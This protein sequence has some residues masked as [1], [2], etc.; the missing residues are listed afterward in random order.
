MPTVGEQLCAARE[1]RKLD[2]SQ[3]ADITKIKSDHIRAL[4]KGDFSCFIAT[5]YIRGFVRTYSRLLKLDEP[6]LLSQLDLELGQ[7]EKFRNQASGN[8][9]S[10]SFLDIVTYRLSR[11]NLKVAGIV[12]GLVA[13]VVVIVFAYRAYY[14]STHENPLSGVK[15]PLTQ[16]GNAAN[17]LPLPAENPAR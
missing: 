8:Y 17:S 6:A 2:I 16:S 4:E 9:G 11:I 12:V 13:A 15:I 7:S 10:R 3:V 5:V 1:A 14:V